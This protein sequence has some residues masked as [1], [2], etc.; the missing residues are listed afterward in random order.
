MGPKALKRKAPDTNEMPAD[1]K[2]PGPGG[3]SA[4][5][6]S[7]ITSFRGDYN[8]LSNFFHSPIVY[9]GLEFPTVEH[10]FQAAKCLDQASKLK[11]LNCNSPTIAKRVGRKVSLRPDW[12]RVKMDIMHD[13][14]ALKFAPNS[15]LGNLLLATGNAELIEGNAWHDNVWGSCV[16][17]KHKNSPGQ[18]KLGK[19]IMGVRD[20]LRSGEKPSSASNV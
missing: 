3:P 2:L 10:A 5:P 11:L 20:E 6:P 4:S 9:D 16:C 1:A 14:L 19:L 15:Q 7:E 13:I 8:F 17:P 18:N 12:E